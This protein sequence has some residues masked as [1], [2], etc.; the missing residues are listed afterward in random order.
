MYSSIK[1][2]RLKTNFVTIQLQNTEKIKMPNSGKN[3]IFLMQ[4]YI[5]AGSVNPFGKYFGIAF[6]EPLKC[7]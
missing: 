3:I 6:H 7:E 4:I 5:S 2:E 1:N